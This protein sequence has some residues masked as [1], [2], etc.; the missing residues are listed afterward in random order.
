MPR[1]YQHSPIAQPA[2]VAVG[3]NYAV[4]EFRGALAALVSVHSSTRH[5]QRQ[6]A[7]ITYW[8]EQ[9]NRILAR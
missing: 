5:A 1:R 3:R 4:G 7:S 9:G 8:G 2:P 6:T